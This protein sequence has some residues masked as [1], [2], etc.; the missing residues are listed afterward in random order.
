MNWIFSP[1][2][3]GLT[4]ALILA[5]AALV[6]L[7][8]KPI[9]K[10]LAG[11]KLG[12]KAKIG[13]LEVSLDEKGQPTPAPRPAGVQFGEGNDFTG[14]TISGVAGRDIRTGRAAAGPE[15]PADGA[16]GGETP[17]GEAPGV[18]FGKRGKFGQA[19]I[20]DVAG[21]DVVKD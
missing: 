11:R 7:K 3:V 21:R 18:D 13:P 12:V 17:A 5:V 10:W 20:R 15:T 1:L 8:R 14:A 4:A 2:G 6:Y 9:K 16:S 19:K